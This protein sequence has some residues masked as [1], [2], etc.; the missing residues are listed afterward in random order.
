MTEEEIPFFWTGFC[1][2]CVQ[3][4]EKALG[5]LLTVGFPEHG[6]ISVESL[7]ADSREH[8]RKTL[9]QLVAKLSKRADVHPGLADRL[10]DFVELRNDFVHRFGDMFQFQTDEGVVEAEL[11]C[12]KLGTEAY[13]LTI[14]LSGFLFAAYDRVSEATGGALS[15]GHEA[16][17]EE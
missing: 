2:F 15:F 7:D 12:Q 4:A 9:G 14:L 5:E 10:N 1:L 8:R 16:L 13:V 3:A 11:F 17:S 6:M